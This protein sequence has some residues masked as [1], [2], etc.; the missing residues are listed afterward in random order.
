M[1][2]LLKHFKIFFIILACDF[3]SVCGYYDLNGILDD[4]LCDFGCKRSEFIADELKKEKIAIGI[5][6]RNSRRCDC[7]IVSKEVEWLWRNEME[8]I[9]YIRILQ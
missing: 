6:K 3:V 8:K 5:Y 7:Y 4:W 9:R 2:K 1:Y